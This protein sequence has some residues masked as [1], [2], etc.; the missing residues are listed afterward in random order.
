MINQSDNYSYYYY[1]ETEPRTHLNNS[2]DLVYTVL[3]FI[4]AIVGLFFNACTITIIIRG[5][6]FGK[7]IKIQLMN[8]AV[9]DVLCSLASVTAE[10]S[11]SVEG[12]PMLHKLN[13]CRMLQMLNPIVF[14]GSL[15]S[16]TAIS[17]ERFVA[18]YFPLKMREYRRRHVITVIATVWVLSVLINLQW[19]LT[20]DIYVH[21]YANPEFACIS[22]NYLPPTKLRIASYAGFVCLPV[23]I[24]VTCYTLICIK[25]KRRKV[26]GEQHR[27]SHSS[28]NIQVRKT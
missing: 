24:I 25:L 15:L 1:N 6:N 17:L 10:I 20:N 2:L 3:T 14:L 12:L 22:Q 8:L 4:L 19:L 7:G 26:I 28:V 18:V 5:D 21:H 13:F 23:L 27:S 9:A 16:N 11:D